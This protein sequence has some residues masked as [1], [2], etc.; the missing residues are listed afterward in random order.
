[1]N[2]IATI[3]LASLVLYG[4]G[5]ASFTMIS[6]K[7]PPTTIIHEEVFIHVVRDLELLNNWLLHSSYPQKEQDILRHQHHQKILALY[8]V[9]PQAFKESV[10]YYLEDSLERSLEVYEKVYLDL[11]AH[12][13]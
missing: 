3:L 10:K 4:V 9:D 1:M 2:K 6:T 5:K 13:L 12:A 8:A 7:H 11:E